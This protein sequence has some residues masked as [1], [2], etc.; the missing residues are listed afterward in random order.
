MKIIIRYILT[1]S[2]GNFTNFFIKIINNE[3][4]VSQ[5]KDI[6]NEKLKINQ[7]QQRLTMK[8]LDD[9]VIEENKI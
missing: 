5:L 8:I 3:I 2:I 6:I 7:S 1:D 9:F 4:L